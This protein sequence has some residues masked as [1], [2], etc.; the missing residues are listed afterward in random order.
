MGQTHCLD[1]NQTTQEWG[2]FILTHNSLDS[3][4]SQNWIK[5]RGKLCLTFHIFTKFP[6]LVFL[7]N[8]NV[9]IIAHYGKALFE[10][11][12]NRDEFCRFHRITRKQKKSSSKMLPPLGNELRA[13]DLLPY[14]LLSE[15]IPYLLEVS[16]HLDLY[17]IML[18][19]FQESSFFIFSWFC[20]IF[21]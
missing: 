2:I 19:W 12:L 20:R 18:Y 11:S 16:R 13:S 1:V 3:L 4:N 21:L 8:L 9:N 17:I 10:F 5:F 15:L 7:H 14:M 6:M